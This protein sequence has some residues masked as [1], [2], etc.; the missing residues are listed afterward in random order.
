MVTPE[1]LVKFA[2]TAWCQECGG[3]EELDAKC[4]IKF[5]TSDGKKTLCMKCEAEI[6]YDESKDDPDYNSFASSLCE[7]CKEARI[8]GV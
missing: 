7:K 5:I 3:I 8:N 4:L 6:D 1:Q 2:G